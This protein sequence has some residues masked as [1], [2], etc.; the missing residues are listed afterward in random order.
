MRFCRSIAAQASLPGFAI[1]L[2]ALTLL[3]AVAT[4]QSAS[5]SQATDSQTGNQSPAASVPETTFHAQSNV[6]I[7]PALVKDAAGHPVYGLTADDFVIEDED[8]P[9]PVHL[10]EAAE[11]EPVS[12]VIAVQTGRKAYREFGRMKGLISMLEPV[13]SE[14]QIE[15][16]VVEF[17]SQI[18]L[19]QDFSQNSSLVEACLSDLQSGD[20]GARI[21]DALQYSVSLLDKRPVGRQRVVL[22]ISET[23]DHGSHWSDLEKAVSMIGDSNT[24]VYALAFS[25]GLSNILDTG[26][27]SNRDEMGGP[28]LLA[29]LVLMS[30]SMRKNTPKTVA[31]MTG[32]EYELF[33]SRRAFEARMLDFTN[34]LHS[35]YLLSFEPR[36]PRP[37]LHKIRVRLKDPGSTVVL[38]RSS[39]WAATEPH[40]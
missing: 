36:N 22:L 32:G 13:L 19:T 10:D 28:D 18:S 7:V 30:Q 15:A 17:D 4:A 3:V 14:P 11:A 8:A 24:A 16:A 5:D 25:P 1:R 34:H 40:K 21:L 9:Q 37:G 27:G 20:G 38:A 35:R 39:Y 12:L 31:E 23:R 2:L 26:R 29:P 6:V 33:K